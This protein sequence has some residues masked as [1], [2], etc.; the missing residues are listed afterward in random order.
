MALDF[1]N[2]YCEVECGTGFLFCISLFLFCWVAWSM[3]KRENR[4]P[5]NRRTVSVICMCNFIVIERGGLG[6]PLR[7]GHG[8]LREKC[9]N[10]TNKFLLADIKKIKINK[11]QVPFGKLNTYP[12]SSRI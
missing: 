3:K 8:K 7:N 12:Q 2:S 4:E 1:C 6:S 11:T 9:S 10:V 5:I